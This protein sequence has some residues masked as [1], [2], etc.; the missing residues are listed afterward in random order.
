MNTLENNLPAMLAQTA[1]A[2]LL[3]FK[4]SMKVDDAL[5]ASI[6]EDLQAVMPVS[7]TATKLTTTTRAM[8]PALKGGAMIDSLSDDIVIHVPAFAKATNAEQTDI[9]VEAHSVTFVLP[10]YDVDS[11]RYFS[12]A[13]SGL[14]SIQP[15]WKHTHND[16]CKLTALIDFVIPSLQGGIVSIL[17]KVVAPV[18]LELKAAIFSELHA[19]LANNGVELENIDFEYSLTRD[20]SAHFTLAGMAR[21]ILCLFNNDGKSLTLSSNYELKEYKK[22]GR[23][24]TLKLSV[25]LGKPVLDINFEL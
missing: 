5:M 3:R 4:P 21:D 13:L 9:M 15:D 7:D 22:V 23:F 19:T 1:I 6:V 25:K 11:V 12:L 18:K 14:V 20:D 24:A 8:L 10:S 16:N 17:T 2:T